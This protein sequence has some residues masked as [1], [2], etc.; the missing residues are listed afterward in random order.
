MPTSETNVDDGGILRF[1]GLKEKH[2]YKKWLLKKNLWAERDVILSDFSFSEMANLINSCGW[3][4]VAGKHYLAYPLLVKEFLAN[5]NHAI[6]EPEGDYR[7]TT[8]VRGKWIKFSPTV[9]ADYCGLLANDIEPIPANLDMTQV[10]Q[11][12][13]GRAD[14]WP[15]IGPKFLHNQLTESLRIFHIFMCHNIDPTSHRTDFNESRA[16]FLYHLACG[17]KID[18]GNH[19]FRFIVDLTSQCVSGR[20]PMF[21]CLISVLCLVEGVPLLPYEEP[22]TPE[23]LI[24]KWTLGHP[25][26]RRAADNPAL[27]PATETDHLLSQI[28][29]Q[30]S[31]QGRVL[32]SIQHTQL[33]M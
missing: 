20:S 7:Y 30:L 16:Q 17:Y 19:I 23:P 21:P 33:A 26:A 8:W 2:I 4:R 24:N 18:L 31:E 3:E 9:I 25:T 22:E 14:A 12:L 32:S 27:I 15:L 10:T 5:L 13:Y 28:F 11:F 1:R 29:T 6:E